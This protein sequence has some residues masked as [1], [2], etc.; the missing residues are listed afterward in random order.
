M[1]TVLSAIGCRWRGAG[2]LFLG[3]L[4][5][6]ALIAVPLLPVDGWLALAIAVLS[7]IGISADHDPGGGQLW[8]NSASGLIFTLWAAIAWLLAGFW[9]V[10]LGLAVAGLAKGPLYR[11][12]PRGSLP[13]QKFLWRERAFGAAW[14]LPGD[15]AILLLFF[16]K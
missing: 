10:A 16:V 5:C 2:H 9:P 6:A 14:G 13:A 8:L 11:L 1:L 4:A 7:F 3:R 12:V 15:V